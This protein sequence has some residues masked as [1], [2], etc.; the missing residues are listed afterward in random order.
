VDLVSELVPLSIPEL[1]H[2]LGKLV[3]PVIQD[4]AKI[5]AWSFWR[6]QHQQRARRSH[7]KRHTQS[8]RFQL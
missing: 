4:V 7:W 8:G 1:R 5:L 6:R 2:L 3:W